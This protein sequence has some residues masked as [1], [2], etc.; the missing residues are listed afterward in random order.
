MSVNKDL[1][2]T[3]GN[4]FTL[5]YPAFGEGCKEGHKTV[6]IGLCSTPSCPNRIGYTI[7]DDF[8]G[9]TYLLCNSCIEDIEFKYAPVAQ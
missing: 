6:H 3:C 4:R 5:P 7:D 2:I 8:C 1:C 9:P